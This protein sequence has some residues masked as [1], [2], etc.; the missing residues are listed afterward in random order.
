MSNHYNLTRERYYR[1]LDRASKSG[2]DVMPFL[3]Y[4][5]EGLRDGLREQLEFV[6]LQQWDV[7][8]RNYVHE[9]FREKTTP[10]AVRQRKLV[11]DLSGLPD[12]IPKQQ[13][14]KISPRIAQLYANKGD[15]TLTRDLNALL[16]MQLIVKDRGGFRAR[17]EAML[18]FLPA[19]VQT[20]A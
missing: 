6:R 10:A 4:A 3:L 14:T 5:V 7:T 2:G 1:E 13:I 11:L 15:R 20:E 19:H 18:A 17:R 8:W 12:P 9:Q 16:N